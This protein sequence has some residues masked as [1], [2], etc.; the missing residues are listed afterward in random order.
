MGVA[1]QLPNVLIEYVSVQSRFHGWW[2]HEPGAPLEGRS[3]LGGDGSG[4]RDVQERARNLAIDVLSRHC[5]G[6]VAAFVVDEFPNRFLVPALRTVS[7]PEPPIIEVELGNSLRRPG[8]KVG[9]TTIKLD[10]S[11]EK[12]AGLD[13]TSRND[14]LFF[15]FFFNSEFSWQFLFFH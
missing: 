9:R 3:V 14:S 4:R 5:V 6:G 12:A 1:H 11:R 13:K 10:K 8:E 2:D 7:V 15:H